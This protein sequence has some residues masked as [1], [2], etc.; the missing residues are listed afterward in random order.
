MTF[1]VIVCLSI[2][3]IILFAGLAVAYNWAIPLLIGAILIGCIAG[4]PAWDEHR[5]DL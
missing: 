3:L 1:R 4:W 2:P 5:Y